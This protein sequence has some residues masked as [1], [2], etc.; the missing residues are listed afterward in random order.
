MATLVNL[1]NYQWGIETAET[2]F[3]IKSH[4]VEVS[5]QFKTYATDRFGNNKGFALGASRL[6]ITQEG[7]VSAT[8]G[9]W[10]SFTF[11][12][13]VTL[14]NDKAY[15]G[16]GITGGVYLDSGTVNQTSDG[17]KTVSM[18]FSADEGIA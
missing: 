3:E 14:A 17:F 7:E 16:T 18:K 13:A 4:N 5:P 15:F 2:G 9:G 6:S 1:T 10:W 12:A 11:N 8:S